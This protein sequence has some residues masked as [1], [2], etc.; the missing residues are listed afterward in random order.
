MKSWT[1]YFQM[2]SKI[3]AD[4]QICISVSLMINYDWIITLYNDFIHV[5]IYHGWKAR[6][7]YCDIKK[8]MELN[9]ICCCCCFVLFCFF[10]VSSPT[11][12]CFICYIREESKNR[13]YETFTH[14]D[15]TLAIVKKQ[16]TLQLLLITENTRNNQ[17]IK[18]KD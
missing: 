6:K 11:K 9:K 3:L 8:E 10:S 4:F 12:E 5:T 7:L 15:S 1:C 13:Y 14:G 17:I 16:K 2:K 18:E